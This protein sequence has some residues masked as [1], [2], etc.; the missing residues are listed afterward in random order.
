MGIR[1]RGHVEFEEEIMALWT[2]SVAARVKL[3]RLG[4]DHGGG[5]LRLVMDEEVSG[6]NRAQS[7][8]I[9]SSKN[10]RKA[11]ARV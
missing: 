6:M 5:G 9:L 11:E 3:N 1:S 4:G 10:W 7:F 2:S 8:D